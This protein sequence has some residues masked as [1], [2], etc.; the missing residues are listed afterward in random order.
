MSK[1][2]SSRRRQATVREPMLRIIGGRLRGRPILYSG[3]RRTRPMKQRIREAI[4]NLLGTA[5]EG[6]YVIDL[7]AGTGALTWEAISRGAIG[8]TLIERHFPTV[9]LIK[10]N[11]EVFAVLDRIAVHGGDTF[12]WAQQQTALQQLPRCRWI[13]FCCPPYD[14]YVDRT[15][16]MLDLVQRLAAAAPGDSQLVVESDRRFDTCQLPDTLAWDIRTYRPAVVAVGEKT[17]AHT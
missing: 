2:S 16:A 3:D 10:K 12:L 5:V 15:D 11:A 17:C 13:V 1:R 6:A 7:F 14:F 8:G 4:F 9:Q